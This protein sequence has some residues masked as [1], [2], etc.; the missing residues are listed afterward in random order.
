MNSFLNWLAS[1]TSMPNYVYFYVKMKDTIFRNLGLFLT[2]TTSLRPT[3]VNRNSWRWSG[4]FKLVNN[5]KGKGH[6]DWQIWRHA[7]CSP[8]V[9]FC[10]K[11]CLLPLFLESTDR[12]YFLNAKYVSIIIMVSKEKLTRYYVNAN[13]LIFVCSQDIFE[14]FLT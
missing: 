4:L 10:I 7:G 9:P 5:V 13:F 11:I 8:V 2:R 14:S 6:F 3:H 1:L 12:N